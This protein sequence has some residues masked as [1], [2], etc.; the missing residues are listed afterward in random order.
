MSGIGRALLTDQLQDLLL[1]LHPVA[2]QVPDILLRVGHRRPVRRIIDAVVALPELVEARHV[3][4]HVAVGRDD[5][6]GR[7]AH[8]MVAAEQG[9]A[10]KRSTDGSRCGPASRP[11]SIGFAVDLDRLAVV[12]HPVGRII[13]VERRIG[14]RAD[15]L[16]RQRRAADDRRAGAL[17]E[18]PRG[19]AVVAVGVGAHDRRD[20]RPAIACS[21]ASRCSGRSGPGSITATSRSPSR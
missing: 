11:R 9:V 8:H 13:A 15:R 6:G 3:G 4:G 2:D 16:Q 10:D 7:P 19:R 17:R 1:A 5:D 18:R 21:S 14:A 20:L 12:E